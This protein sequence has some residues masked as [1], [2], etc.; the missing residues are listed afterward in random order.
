MRRG[1]VLLSGL[2]GALS[3]ASPLG[4]AWINVPNGSF[5]SPGLASP[6]VA[7]AMGYGDI[8]CW[9]SSSR[10]SDGLV[11][12]GISQLGSLVGYPSGFADG[13]QFAFILGSGSLTSAPLTQIAANTQYT[14]TVA[15]G[16]RDNGSV[17]DYWIELLANGSPIFYSPIFDG[18][19]TSPGTWG[20]VKISYVTPM[21]GGPVGQWLSARLHHLAS[22]TDA[23]GD[24]DN[25]RLQATLFHTP[26]P[27]AMV[28]WGS[29]VAVGSIVFWRRR[30]QR[31]SR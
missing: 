3:I 25:V 28:A 16:H 17:G 23:R 7:F 14:L 10:S 18:D 9:T 4:A 12:A 27:S 8:D 31:L 19:S 1:L 13:A 2:V 24:F 11:Y 5:E 6:N 21:S 15:V 29:L 26:E 30:G 22:T 20:E